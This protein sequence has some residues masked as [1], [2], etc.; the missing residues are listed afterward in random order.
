MF[1]FI[2]IFFLSFNLFY[3][4]DLKI[5]FKEILDNKN[6]NDD[7]RISKIYG[8]IYKNNSKL[9]TKFFNE[10]NQDYKYF[11]NLSYF[12]LEKT[13]GNYIK[14][15][16]YI[17]KSLNTLEKKGK[18]EN[19]R[20]YFECYFNLY[21]LEKQIGNSKKSLVYLNKIYELYLQCKKIKYY[22]IFLNEMGVTNRNIGNYNDALN[23]FE[24][25]KKIE[26]TLSE[27]NG[28]DWVSLHI[29]RTH[30]MQNKISE[31]KFYYDEVLHE[32]NQNKNYK[33][34]LILDYEYLLV[35]VKSNKKNEAIKIGKNIIKHDGNSQ[36]SQYEMPATYLELG[37]I[38]FKNNQ[39]DSALYYL[40]KSLNKSLESKNILNSDE[41]LSY[42][43]KYEKLPSETNKN[44]LAYFKYLS[45]TNTLFSYKELEN[46]HNSYS[47]EIVDKELKN[48]KN[49]ATILSISLIIFAFILF[50]SYKKRIK[51]NE[52]IEYQKL[53]LEETNN[54]LIVN[55]NNLLFTLKEQE[56]FINTLAH[57]IKS[58]ILSIILISKKNLNDI[59]L[60]QIN[61]E[62][63]LIN[64]TINSILNNKTEIKPKKKLI[65]FNEIINEV[66]K[67]LNHL[68]IYTE[69]IINVNIDENVVQFYGYKTNFYQ[70]F[71]NLIENALKYSSLNK[72]CE[73][74][75][76]ISKNKNC[77][78]IEITDNGIG[79]SE[80]KLNKMNEKDF[81]FDI[82]KTELGYGLGI[83]ICKRIVNLYKGHFKFE[84]E[85]DKF[86]KVTIILN[87]D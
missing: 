69:P 71:K 21:H 78:Q 11:T 32:M 84:S 34:K 26:N 40:S 82:Q 53:K 22:Y 63:I 7:S 77:I 45:K 62:A 64:E 24:E 57:D 18:I 10:F 60:M 43:L 55:Y 3:A 66:L 74:D 79:I 87:N 47:I 20:L 13:N 25:A 68:I 4:N 38:Y 27:K 67:S 59:K 41:T 16:N 23:Y 70:L 51:L 72:K 29:G 52:K 61:D 8:F 14:A 2:L 12:Y 44:I 73:I 58:S 6:L 76:H 9:N 35:A 37:K 48:K 81:N 31:A 39:K 5:E 54:N 65:T 28:F 42:L 49:I 1:K 30:L 56:F 75:I 36:F 83:N 15:K 19:N 33:N 50:Y 86:T 46:I 17:I 80:E 85:L